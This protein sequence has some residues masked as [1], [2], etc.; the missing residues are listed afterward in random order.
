[1]SLFRARL[2]RP[3]KISFFRP[4][5][6]NDECLHLGLSSLGLFRSRPKKDIIFFQ[7][8][9]KIFQAYPKNL[10]K[11]SLIRARPHWLNKISF[12]D[13]SDKISSYR[14]LSLRSI[15]DK[16]TS[17]RLIPLRT[18]LLKCLH[19]GLY[20]LG[21]FRLRPKKRYYLFLGLP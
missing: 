8:C 6:V 18:V 3:N 1:M 4:L 11:M 12:Q 2:L 19:L 16:I 7:G 13:P 5:L 21:L 17:F 14:A 10:I 15:R 9:P 20:S